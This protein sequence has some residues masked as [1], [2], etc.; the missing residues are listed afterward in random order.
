METS[1]LDSTNIQKA[2]ENI[3]KEMYK[4]F[5]KEKKKEKIEKSHAEGVKIDI[6]EKQNEIEISNNSGGCC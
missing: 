3:L 5:K 1:A 6:N 4:E 2:F